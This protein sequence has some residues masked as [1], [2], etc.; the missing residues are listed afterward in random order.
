M[1]QRAAGRRGHREQPVAGILPHGQIA[2]E[3]GVAITEAECGGDS[4]P[5]MNDAALGQRHR[6]ITAKA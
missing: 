2:G 3:Q 5:D 6:R 4:D 1:Q